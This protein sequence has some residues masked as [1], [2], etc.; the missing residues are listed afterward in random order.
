MLLIHAETVGARLPAIW[1]AA[2]AKSGDL[3]VPDTPH[4]P[5]LL[6]VPG[7]SRDKPRSYALQAE[8][9]NKAEHVL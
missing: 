5:V 1:R 7:R 3:V 9:F 8:A 6:P 2:A 4:A